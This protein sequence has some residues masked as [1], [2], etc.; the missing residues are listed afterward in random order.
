MANILVTGGAGYIG[1]NTARLLLRRGHEVM[2]VDDLSRG[3]HHNVAPD[4]LRVQSLMDTAGLEKLFAQTGFD[5]VVHFAA[6]IAVGESVEKPEMYFANNVGGT[7]SLLKAMGQAGVRKLVFS[8]TAA[9]Y[10]IPERVPIPEEAP[11][12]PINPYGASKAMVE[13]IL[14][15]LDRSSG[16]RSVAL[17]YFNACGAEPDSGLGE[18]HDPE[19]HLIPLMLRAVATGRPLTVFGD[20]YATPDGTCIRDYVHISDLAEA[21][22]L[23]LEHLLGGGSSEVFNAGTGGGHSVLEVIAAAEQVT[24]RTVPRRIGPRREGDPP[25]LVADASRLRRVLGWEPRYTGLREIVATAWEFE[26]RRS[27]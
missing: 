13:Q 1:S 16:L 26:R 21:H 17:R 27:R 8:S 22:A 7:L 6:F 12:R 9:V 2:V 18:E 14:G 10:G 3:Y 20:D 4:R 24:G 23:A 25:E 19:T 5:A 15:W 11:V